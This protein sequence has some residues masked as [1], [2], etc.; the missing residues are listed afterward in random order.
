MSKTNHDATHSH[1]FLRF[2]LLPHHLHMHTEPTIRT[3]DE[4]TMLR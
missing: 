2:P 4:Q 1:Y 3:F